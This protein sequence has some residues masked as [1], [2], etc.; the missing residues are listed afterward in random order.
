MMVN[1]T[2]TGKARI[3]WEWLFKINQVVMPIFMTAVMSW[4][5]WV[6]NT[7]YQNRSG[8]DLNREKMATKEW[9]RDNFPSPELRNNIS[10]LTKAVTELE[11][12]VSL[13]TYKIDSKI[14]KNN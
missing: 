11:K 13:L 6:T 12:A 8:I 3:V 4:A 9:V 7:V 10:G 5:V 14:S 1:N 2:S